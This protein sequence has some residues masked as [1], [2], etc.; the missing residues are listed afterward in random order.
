[1]L[2]KDGIFVELLLDNDSDGD[3][4]CMYIDYKNQMLETVVINNE[5]RIFEVINRQVSKRTVRER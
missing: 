1:M 4:K 5:N 3:F 2:P